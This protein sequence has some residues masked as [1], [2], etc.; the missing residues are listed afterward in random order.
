MYI[1]FMTFGLDVVMLKSLKFSLTIS[2]TLI[3]FLQLS[4]C[5]YVIIQMKH[6]VET[7][8]GALGSSQWMLPV[9]WVE[10]KASKLHT[11]KVPPEDLLPLLTF[12]H[13]CY[14][15]LPFLF[16]DLCLLLLL[17]SPDVDPVWLVLDLHMKYIQWRWSSYVHIV[18]G[19]LLCDSSPIYK[20][21]CCLSHRYTLSDDWQRLID[22]Q[23]SLLSKVFL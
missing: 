17:V 11:Q 5:L 19:L 1:Y 12:F 6:M 22:C 20:M 21:C 16:I 9:E 7:L 23:F 18:C 3:V 8:K 4:Y 2:V 10:E 14:L 13:F 15:L